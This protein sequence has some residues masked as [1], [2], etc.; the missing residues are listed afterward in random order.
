[1]AEKQHWEMQAAAQK[2]TH[3]REHPGYRYSNYRT[4]KPSASFKTLACWMRNG[5][6]ASPAV[7]SESYHLFILSFASNAVRNWHDV[8]ADSQDA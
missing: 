6:V 4:R 7:M 1:V 3:Q 5:D 8:D 2:E